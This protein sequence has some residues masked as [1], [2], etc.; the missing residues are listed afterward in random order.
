MGK[1]CS[2]TGCGRSHY[3]RGYCYSHYEQSRQGIPLRPIGPYGGGECSV[4]GCAEPILSLGWC[5]LHY[6]RSRRYGDP[7]AV[8]PPRRRWEPGPCDFPGCTNVRGRRRWYCPSHAR[9]LLRGEELRPLVR[10]RPRKYAV[11]QYFFDEINTEEKAYWLGFI[12]ADGCITAKAHALTINLKAADAGHLEKLRLALSSD[13]P[14]RPSGSGRSCGGIVRWQAN[15]V[16][17]V[18]ALAILGITPRKSA[19][20]VPWDGPEHLMPH[21][22]RGM[23]DGDGGISFTRNRPGSPLQ[24]SIHL[25]GSR[26]C[27]EGFAKWGADLCGSRAQPRPHNHSR[28]CWYWIVGGNRMVPLIVRELYGD[29]TISLDRKQ[30]LADA[31]L[32]PTRTS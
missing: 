10:I 16:P 26:A 3:C 30:A 15:S 13:S 31:I 23:V 14:I 28:D 6:G 18:R 17:L 1:T 8:P 5:Q 12:T 27:V 20:A 2:F 21:Y 24:W 22:W 19:T 29:C 7:L 32:A 4:T 11:D 9:Q 25:T